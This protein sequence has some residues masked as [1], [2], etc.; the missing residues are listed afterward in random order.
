MAQLKSTNILGN[1]AVSGDILSSKFI[2]LGGA[3]TEILMADGAVATIHDLLA[4]ALQFSTKANDAAWTPE[5]VRTK[6]GSGG[7]IRRGTW[8]YSGNGY[9]AKGSTAQSQCPFGA[10]DLAGATVLQANAGPT[11]YTQLYITASTSSGTTGAITGEMIYY[12]DN[13]S[14]YTPTWRRVLTNNNFNVYSPA[15][16]GTGATGDWGIDITGNAATATTAT[17]ATKLGTSAG[18][19]NTPVYFSS[20]KPVACSSL[21]LN[22]SGYSSYIRRKFDRDTSNYLD[23]ITFYKAD[24]TTIALC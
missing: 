16:D 1:L 20:G 7:M 10:I 24:N 13:G 18:D 22:T 12:I 17:T 8:D 15:L 23:A 19:S 5:E 2:K 6:I 21:D 14:N 4:A 3:S 9:I 11:A